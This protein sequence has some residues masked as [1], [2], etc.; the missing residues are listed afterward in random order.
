MHFQLFE[1]STLV[2]K[3]LGHP[4]LRLQID[5]GGEFKTFIPFL[6]QH[7][8]EYHISCPH[9]SQQNGCLVLNLIILF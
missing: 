9:T 8:I 4:I 6:T 1:N 5:R 3:L 2:K 7:D